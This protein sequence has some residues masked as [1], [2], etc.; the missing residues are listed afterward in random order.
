MNRV[1]VLGCAGSGKSHVSRVLAEKLGLPIIYFDHHGWSLDG[2]SVNK[3]EF[4]QKIFSIMRECEDKWVTD[5]NHS[6]DDELTK[7]RFLKSD[8]IVLLDFC[9]QDCTDAIRTRHGQKRLDIPDGFTETPEGVEQLVK[10]AGKWFLDKKPELILSQAR[11]YSAQNKLVIL[12]NRAQVD[13][14]LQSFKL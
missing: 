7:Y 14:F 1:S 12:K 9:E 10:H 13:E 3:D 6:R 8:L 11:K 2:A 5:G 4:V